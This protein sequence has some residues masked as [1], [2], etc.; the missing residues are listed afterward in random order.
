MLLIDLTKRFEELGPEKEK[1][2][3][4]I[5][6][7][8]NKKSS[9]ALP[10][11]RRLDLFISNRK[12]NKKLVPSHMLCYFIYYKRESPAVPLEY[13]GKDPYFDPYTNITAFNAIS[14]QMQLLKH[15]QKKYFDAF[16]RRQK[17]PDWTFLDGS[18]LA[19]TYCQLMY[20]SWA[21]STGLVSRFQQVEKIK[22]SLS[23]ASDNKESDDLILTR[24]SSPPRMYVYPTYMKTPFSIPSDDEIP[25]LIDSDN[26]EVSE[27]SRGPKVVYSMFNTIPVTCPDLLD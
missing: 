27:T 25:T 11:L 26:V 2:M 13:C 15:Y 21:M 5:I 17:I 22:T 4:L 10:S 8:G 16:K 12:L 19:T 3:K 20:L 1:I 7:L 14:S 18:V 9:D 23:D 6:H 24:E